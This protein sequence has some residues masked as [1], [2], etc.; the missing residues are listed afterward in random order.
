M[1][2]CGCPT[3][4]LA[5]NLT[6]AIL[7]TA[8]AD[9]L[10]AKNPCQIKGASKVTGKKR[11]H[12]TLDHALAIVEKLPAHLQ[13]LVI[14]TW[15]SSVRL[16]EAL[17]LRWEDLDIDGPRALIDGGLVHVHRQVVT[18]GTDLI[19]TLP[20]AHSD[21]FVPIPV[22][23]VELLR[24]HKFSA[25][26]VLPSA[27][28]F[29]NREGLPLTPHA[30]GQAWRRARAKAELPQYRFHDLRHGS[31]TLAAQSGATLYEVM[32]RLGHRS[33]NA[34]IGYQHAASERGSVI[35]ASMVETARQTTARRGQSRAI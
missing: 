25:G 9:E 23:T 14:V 20:K 6:K 7:T 28:V 33:M 22:E 10:I 3:V 12:M 29:T 17:A 16:G 31:A 18:I 21:R 26:R 27:R 13:P 5:Y 8:V 24:N 32:Q 34:A 4:C 35:A 30:V 1:R 19:E 15:W 2:T 11:P